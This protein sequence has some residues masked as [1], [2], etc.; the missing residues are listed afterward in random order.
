[1]KNIR[2]L[3]SLVAGVALLLAASATKSSAV[4]CNFKTCVKDKG[5]RPQG[6]PPLPIHC[7]S[8]GTECKNEVCF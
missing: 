2:W 5:C 3:F 4:H 1:M 8:I 6:G 7:V